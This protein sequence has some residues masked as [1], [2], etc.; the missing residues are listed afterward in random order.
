MSNRIFRSKAVQSEHHSPPSQYSGGILGSVT[1]TTIKV[2]SAVRDRLA[3]L[4]GERGTTIRNLVQRLADGTPTQA[5]LRSRQEQAAGYVR[6]HLNPN[7]S[8]A[9]IDA[10]R[11]FWDDL[12]SGDFQPVSPPARGLGTNES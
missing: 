4:A 3:V 7:L 6:A 1:D 2:D 10:G 12:R 11:A 9:D 5:E 8:D